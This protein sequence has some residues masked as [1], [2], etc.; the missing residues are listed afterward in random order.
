LFVPE[1]GINLFSLIVAGMK[2]YRVC[3]DNSHIQ[4]VRVQDGVTGATDTRRGKSLYRMNMRV[5]KPVCKAMV[6]LT[7]A[8]NPKT[9]KLQFW[10][11][12][13]CHQ[14]KK[15]VQEGVGVPTDDYF[16]VHLAK[17][18]FAVS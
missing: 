3:A 14:N 17:S 2:G 6:H 4:L 16:C 5:V 12:R 13:L 18:P 11:E 9:E 10:H 15:H 8:A 1:L 7:S